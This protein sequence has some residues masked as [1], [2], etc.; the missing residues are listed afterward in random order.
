M[1]NLANSPYNSLAAELY[2]SP[3]SFSD[4][5]IF[6]ISKIISKCVTKG[7][8]PAINRNATIWVSG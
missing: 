3:A 6:F 4:R 8:S 1:F 2:A 5:A 7:K